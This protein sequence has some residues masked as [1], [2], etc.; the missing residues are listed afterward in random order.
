MDRPGEVAERMDAKV[1]NNSGHCKQYHLACLISGS[2]EKKK[3]HY[4]QH[5]MEG[6]SYSAKECRKGTA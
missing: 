1:V 6:I 2:L 4:C 5:S 3:H